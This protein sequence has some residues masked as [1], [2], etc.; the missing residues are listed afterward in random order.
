LV[1]LSD[2]TTDALDLALSA[3]RLVFSML[4]LWIGC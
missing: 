4:H 1:R 2:S 3:P